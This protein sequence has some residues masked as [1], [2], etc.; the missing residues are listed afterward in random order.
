MYRLLDSVDICTQSSERHK[1]HVLRRKCQHG[2]ILLGLLLS[3][4]ACNLQQE[5]PVPTPDLPIVTITEPENNRQVF[6]GVNVTIEIE[7]L[8]ETVGISKV[9]LYVDDQLLQTAEI[10][11]YQ[12]EP[13]FVV[14]MSW[15]A[16]GIGLHLIEA[17]AYRAGDIGSRPHYIELEV[18]PRPD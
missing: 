8:D 4:A 3:L 10:P 1:R 13:I 2:L 7:A 9:E 16:E 15:R 18:I 11:N 5:T 12:V 17:R 6:E 14:Q